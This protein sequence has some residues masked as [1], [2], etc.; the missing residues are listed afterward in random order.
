MNE[1]QESNEG[2]II[3]ICATAGE[4]INRAP[5]KIARQTEAPRIL[6]DGFSPAPS[7]AT[8]AGACHVTNG[9]AINAPIACSK[10]RGAGGIG[11]DF[12]SG[13]LLFREW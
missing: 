6:L 7:L 12:G 8:D 1:A 10:L 2:V 4:V 11:G 3:L 5:T 9:V 13:G